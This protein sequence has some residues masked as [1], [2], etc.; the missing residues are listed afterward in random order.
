[1]RYCASEFSRLFPECPWVGHATRRLQVLVA[2][3]RGLVWCLREQNEMTPEDDR[4]RGECTAV[5][6]SSLR[7]RDPI[8][9]A[10]EPTAPP[11]AVL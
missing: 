5:I 3:A 9:I 8:W 6:F 11:R 1:M 2:T 7:S 10:E 4:R